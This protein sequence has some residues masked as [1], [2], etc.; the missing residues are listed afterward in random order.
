MGLSES[1][2][3]LCY[4]AACAL[5][6]QGKL[7]EAFNKLQQAEGRCCLFFSVEL[8]NIINHR[9]NGVTSFLLQSIAESLYQRIR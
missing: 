5:I 8:D 3:E 6:G 2:Y 7:T 4:N 9:S 1:T